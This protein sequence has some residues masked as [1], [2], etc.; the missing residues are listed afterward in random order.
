M[1]GYVS[2]NVIPHKVKFQWLKTAVQ[3]HS[4]TSSNRFGKNPQMRLLSFVHKPDLVLSFY[5]FS[6]T[7]HCLAKPELISRLEQGLVPWSGAEVTEQCLPGESMLGHKSQQVGHIEMFHQ[8]LSKPDQSGVGS[9]ITLILYNFQIR[10][11]M[12]NHFPVLIEFGLVV[13]EVSLYLL[14][15]T[16]A[17][18]D[19]SHNFF[20]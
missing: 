14:K 10:D 1:L 3:T 16:T 15:L 19:F 5:Y 9:W 17:V 6:F 12:L 18:W 20:G 13:V 8:L 7:G 11:Y 2:Y 4:N